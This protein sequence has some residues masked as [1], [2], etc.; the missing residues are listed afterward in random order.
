MATSVRPT[1]VA[2]TFY[3]GT[4]AALQSSLMELLATAEDADHSIRPKA[5]VVPHAGYI[6]SGLVAARA[7]AL[8]RPVKDDIR[9]VVMFG[10]AHRVRVDGLAVPAVAAF[11]TPLGLVPVD[12]TAVAIASQLT[13]VHSSDAAHLPEHS[14]EVQLPFLQAVL[15]EFAIVPFV[16]GNASA[17]QVAEVIELLWGG[18][19]TLILISSDLS[20]YLPYAQA[21][22]ADQESVEAILCRTPL[23]HYDQ[24]CGA[25]PINGLIEVARRRNLTAKLLDL[26]NSG[27]TAGDKSRVVGYA[28]FAF[29]ESTDGR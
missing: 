4:A 29:S 2:G 8:L 5:L 25:T 12:Q 27:D 9:R 17:V 28:A 11:A 6:Y 24:A 19:E 22:R 7:Y 10:P 26:R 3:P 21:Q 20:H 13:Q 1:A 18:V 23:T 14:L 16:V 15:E